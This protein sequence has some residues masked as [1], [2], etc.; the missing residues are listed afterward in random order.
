[1]HHCPL[2][3]DIAFAFP[4][5]PEEVPGQ[6]AGSVHSHYLCTAK[7]P[8]SQVLQGPICQKDSHSTTLNLTNPGSCEHQTWS[9]LTEEEAGF[10]EWKQGM[11]KA[12]C[13]Q[14]YCMILW[15]VGHFFV[16]MPMWKLIFVDRLLT[17]ST[18]LC[19][20]LWFT[21]ESSSLVKALTCLSVL[22]KWYSEAS[23][24]ALGPELWIHMHPLF[25]KG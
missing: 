23:P 20:R 24:S 2:N 8:F 12:L 5:V 4:S 15:E 19:D 25:S 6:A 7:K 9:P 17:P 21:L 18:L 16:W 14:L 11:Q 10:I 1:M 13:S 3:L 22:S